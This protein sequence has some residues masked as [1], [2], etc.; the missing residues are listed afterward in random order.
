RSSACASPGC[1]EPRAAVLAGAVGGS[2]AA[3]LS[4]G[5]F[6]DPDAESAAAT[7]LLE[8]EFR[9]G[10]PNLT[11]LVTAAGGSVDDPAVAAAGRQLTAQLAAE[12]GVLQ[13]VSYWTTQA[14]SLKSEG[15]D[16][17]LVLGRLTGSEDEQIER[18]ERIV[19]E[20]TTTAL[21]GREDLRVDV[22]GEMEGY[23]Q[24]GDTIEADLKRAES[25]AIPITAVL[26]VLVFGSAVAAGLPLLVGV[27]S[28]LGTFF[29]LQLLQGV[30]DVSVYSVNLAISLGLGLG[31]DYSLFMLTRYREERAG[32]LS[33]RAAVVRTVQTAGRTV[34][35]SAVTVLLSLAALL[36]FPLYFLRS[37]AYAG[38]SA[39]LFAAVGAVVVLPAA[40][41]VL[42]RRIDSFDLGKPLRRALRLPPRRP[43]AVGEGF[44]HRLAVTVMRRPVPIAT[45]VLLLLVGAGLPFTQVVFGLPDDRVLP[46]EAGA[47]VTAQTIRDEFP[48]NEPLALT[49][50]VQGTGPAESRIGDI[51]AWAAQLSQVDGVERVDA[52]TGSYAGGQQVAPP[53]PAVA[54]AA[55]DDGTYVTIVPSGEGYGPEGEALVERVRAVDAPFDD[56]LVAGQAA[57]LADTKASLGADLPVALGLIVVATLVLL[58]LFTGSVVLPVKAIVLNLLSLSATFGAMVWVFQEGNLTWLVGDPIVTGTLDTTTPILMFCVL[59]GLSMDY[60]VFLLSRIRE[61]WL[62]TGDNRAAVALGLERT[63]R[64]ITAA[65]GLLAIVFIAFISS[66][67]SFIKLLGL[68]T[69]LAVVVD[70]TLVRGAL[71]PA[72]MRL[73]GRWN[74]WAPAPL[75]RLHDRFGLAEAELGDTGQVPDVPELPE[76]VRA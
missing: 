8:T 29:T 60:E 34:L 47:H 55:G 45:V 7:R 53:S 13:V 69:A 40:L 65:A 11:L 76:P 35:F 63:G 31:I 22:G 12:E 75:R 56:V 1:A 59:F 74:W 71:V 20:Y 61:E 19:E 21:A 41:I 72:F 17:A 2:V 62:R 50:V 46:R 68:G 73:A 57:S 49:A 4:A 16:R 27:L 26:L 15:G 28:I 18:V 66:G 30:T 48:S 52:L 54:S 3:N 67:I 25:I 9:A 64:L 38:V 14:P 37:F 5:G 24:V 39:V 51:A 44:W 42:G 70:A 10:A 33:D 43:K 58:F 6:D 32:G 36:V 23:R